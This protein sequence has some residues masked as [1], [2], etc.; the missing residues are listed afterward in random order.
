M[1]QLC[2]TTLDECPVQGGICD[3]PMQPAC[4]LRVL[5]PHPTT[6]WVHARLRRAGR[7][8]LSP[9]HG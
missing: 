6:K 3:D 8:Q 2:G 9:S 5:F 7:L 1:H 4:S